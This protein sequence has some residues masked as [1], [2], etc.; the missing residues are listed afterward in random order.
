MRDRG[1]TALTSGFNCFATYKKY[2]I[3]RSTNIRV[4]VAVRDDSEIDSQRA[5]FFLVSSQSYF[6]KPTIHTEKSNTIMTDVESQ[7]RSMAIEEKHSNSMVD[8]ENSIVIDQEQEE[9]TNVLNPSKSDKKHGTIKP[10]KSKTSNHPK[11]KKKSQKVAD[12]QAHL[13]VE[14]TSAPQ[15]KRSSKEKK[16]KNHHY[17]ASD[18]RKVFPPEL[19]EG[20]VLE[21]KTQSKL[22]VGGHED[23][24]EAEEVWD[25][26]NPEEDYF[27]NLMKEDLEQIE[28]RV[29][30]HKGKSDAVK[31]D[32]LPVAMPVV[33]VGVRG[34]TSASLGDRNKVGNCTATA[35]MVCGIIGLVVIGVILGTLA[36]ILGCIAIGQI[37]KE[38]G[39][40]KRNAKC[41]AIAGI[42]IGIVGLVAWIIIG[43]VYIEE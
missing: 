34:T 41:Q 6:I 18:E 39:K 19:Q 9:D 1:D 4:C 40:Y 36:V 35:A 27:A 3:V 7:Q 16:S 14:S 30:N 24:I 5:F 21:V 43:I 28:G 32:T 38:P 22:A 15:P 11:S 8:D 31:E 25:V 33:N 12:A 20:V 2:H 17:N 10:K 23:T 42:I 26:E 29:E 13:S 37:N